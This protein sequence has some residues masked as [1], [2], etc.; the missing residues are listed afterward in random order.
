MLDFG[1]KLR[2]LRT[3]KKLTQLELADLTGVPYTHISMIE[4]GK[5]L[6]GAHYEKQIKTALD[7]PADEAAFDV[8]TVQP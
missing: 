4:T 2:T 1:T 7:W 8:L 5:M 6:P 3:L